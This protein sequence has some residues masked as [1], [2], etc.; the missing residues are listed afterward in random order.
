LKPLKLPPC[1]LRIKEGP[2][3]KLIFD[4]LRQKYV[5]FTP[6]EWV[7]QHFVNYL[8]EY[9]HYPPGLIQVEASLRLNTMMRRADILIHDRSGQPVM[10]IECKAPDVKLTQAVV[11]QVTN[12]NFTY[13]VMY[14]VI[15]NGIIH[16]PVK[17][18]TVNRTFV[19]LDQIPDYE[20]V[21]TQEP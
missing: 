2:G 14:L 13:G 6:E 9:L 16:W 17:I 3:G 10:V 5:T 4:R 20:S 19:R 18:D 8:T 12:Y 7:R 21:I 1:S 15:T 11:D